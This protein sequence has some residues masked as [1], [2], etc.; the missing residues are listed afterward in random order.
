MKDYRIRTKHLLQSLSNSKG[1][2]RVSLNKKP[3]HA[4]YFNSKLL[5]GS[6]FLIEKYWENNP[7]DAAKEQNASSCWTISF[8]ISCVTSPVMPSWQCSLSNKWHNKNTSIATYTRTSPGTAQL[9]FESVF[10]QI[11]VSQATD[12]ASAWSAA[13]S[14]L[15]WK[16][17]LR[18]QHTVFVLRENHCIFT[19]IKEE[20]KSIH[21]FVNSSS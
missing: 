13:T 15:P 18:P 3:T 12:L 4:T 10:T 11:N 14:F 8:K 7:K 9:K 6:V 2:C 1:T 17:S 21:L 5:L 19:A 16:K 20:K